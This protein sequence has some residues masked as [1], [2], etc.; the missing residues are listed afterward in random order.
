MICTGIWNVYISLLKNLRNNSE[1]LDAAQTCEVCSS[2]SSH[3]LFGSGG[4]CGT[5]LEVLHFSKGFTCCSRCSCCARCDASQG[6]EGNEGNEGN[7][8]YHKWPS[9]FGWHWCQHVGPHVSRHLPR[10]GKASCRLFG[11]SCK[12]SLSRCQ[13]ADGHCWYF[14]GESRCIEA[15]PFLWFPWE[16]WD[17]RTLLHSRS[18]PNSLLR[19]RGFSSCCRSRV[20]SS[21]VA[22]GC[23]RGFWFLYGCGRM[24]SGLWQIAILPP[25]NSVEVLPTTIGWSSNPIAKATIFTLSNKWCSKRSFKDFDRSSIWTAFMPWSCAQFWWK[26]WRCTQLYSTWILYWDQWMLSEDCREL[27]DGETTSRGFYPPRDW[28]TV[29]WYQG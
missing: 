8:K 13:Q 17:A 14:A 28:C 18:P 1:P 19:V 29:V 15:L 7:H 23:A 27:G 2:H 25:R 4:W 21:A 3:G 12:S 26:H 24:R 6:S 5:R 11:S 9:S 20:L 22:D 16:I 10:K